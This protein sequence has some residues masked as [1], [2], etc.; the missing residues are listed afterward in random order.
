MSPGNYRKKMTPETNSS[1]LSG[2]SSIGG[3]PETGDKLVAESFEEPV[4]VV[5]AQRMQMLAAGG[6]IACRHPGTRRRECGMRAQA[7]RHAALPGCGKMHTG[8][9]QLV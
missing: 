5:A 7:I 6:C 9:P 1:A 3:V 8:K 2:L 4:V